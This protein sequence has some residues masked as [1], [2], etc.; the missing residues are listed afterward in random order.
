M[1]L[2]A[3]CLDVGERMV[4]GWRDAEIYLRGQETLQEAIRLHEAG[5]E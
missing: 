4:W 1:F 3:T 5:G 2:E